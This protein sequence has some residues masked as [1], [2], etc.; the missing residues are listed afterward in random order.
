M[1]INWVIYHFSLVLINFDVFVDNSFMLYMH[2]ITDWIVGALMW[3]GGVQTKDQ[4]YL[5]L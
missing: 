4:I 3:L 5:Q 1:N 2:S